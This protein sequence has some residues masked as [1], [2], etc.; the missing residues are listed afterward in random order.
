[1]SKNLV[2]TSLLLFCASSFAGDKAAGE[3]VFKQINCAM[4]HNKDGMG[5]AKNGKLSILKAPRIAGLNEAYIVSQITDIQSQKR[6]T[7]FTSMMYSK[8]K[9]L[10]KEDIAN[11]AAYVS[12]LSKDK[13]KGMLEK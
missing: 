6:K 13:A 4:C 1:M 11:V 9:K 7:K 5:K 3:K 10:S 2:F 8:V 12:S